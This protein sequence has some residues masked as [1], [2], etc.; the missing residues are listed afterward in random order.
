MRRSKPVCADV[1]HLFRKLNV[2]SIG[3]SALSLWLPRADIRRRAWPTEAPPT[4]GRGDVT[5]SAGGHTGDA[6]ITLG[7]TDFRSLLLRFG[8][9]AS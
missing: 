9:A 5:D 1:E 4:A 2:S 8:A 3:D 6:C 7:P